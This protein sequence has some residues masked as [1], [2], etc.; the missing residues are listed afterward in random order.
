MRTDMNPT[1]ETM[2]SESVPTAVRLA[3]L[4]EGGPTGR[5]FRFE[6]ELPMLPSTE[7][8]FQSGPR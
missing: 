6:R 7:V 1:A 2:P 4:P 5:F 3:S 8:D